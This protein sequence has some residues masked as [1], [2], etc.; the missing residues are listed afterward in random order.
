MNI[1]PVVKSVWVPASP[2]AA[3]VRFTDELNTWWPRSDHSVSKTRCVDVRFDG[4][5][6]GRLYEVDDAGNEFEWGRIQAWE[7]GA[8]FM[9]SWHPGR[10]AG[11]AQQ[12]EVTFTVENDGTRVELTHRGW[13]AIG[14]TAQDARNSY[15]NGWPGVLAIYSKAMEAAS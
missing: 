5:V 1:E 9:V 10:P 6:G 4:E 15:N 11:E 13:E 14:A 12:V 7:P 3:F 8:R 2:A